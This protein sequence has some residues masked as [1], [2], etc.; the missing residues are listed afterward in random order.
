M[1]FKQIFVHCCREFKENVSGKLREHNNFRT[2]PTEGVVK[3]VQ[4]YP[5]HRSIFDSCFKEG[6]LLTLR[7]VYKIFGGRSCVRFNQHGDISLIAPLYYVVSSGG[8]VD[9]CRGDIVLPVCKLPSFDE[10]EIFQVFVPSSSDSN[11]TENP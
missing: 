2:N 10:E 8:H 7:L 9:L 3:K 5:I 4:H 11:V 6:S 1:D